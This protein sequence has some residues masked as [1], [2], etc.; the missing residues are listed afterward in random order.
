MIKFIAVAFAGLFFAFSA[1]ADPVFGVWKTQPGNE[2]NYAH[3]EIKEC[4]GKICGEMVKAFDTSD[5]KIDSK[6]IGR[7]IIF[8]MS[9][10]KGG[11]YG[12]G[13]I[14]APDEDKNYKSKMKLISD[15]ELHVSGCVAICTPLTSRKQTWTRVK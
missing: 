5:K 7:N 10:K 4:D 2:G 11:K 1:S 12:G 14:W 6:N 9:P 13:K 15:N 8:D 3:V